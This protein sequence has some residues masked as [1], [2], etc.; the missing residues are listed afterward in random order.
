MD[1]LSAVLQEL[2]FNAEVFFSGS[3]CGLQAFEQSDNNGHLHLMRAG[4]MTMLTDQ[5]HEV[6]LQKASVLFLPSGG[7]HRIQIKDSHDAELVCA[8]VQFDSH[9][10]SVL[11][12]NL[13]KFICLDVETN[14]S[15][16]A[17]VDHIFQEAFS[18]QLGKK[19]V[20]DRL[21]DVFVVQVLRYVIEGGMVDAGAF[22]AATHPQL[23][24]LMKQLKS[25]P[26][27]VWT[28]ESM[29]TFAA[30]SRSKFAGLFKDSVGQSPMEYLTQLRLELAKELLLKNK[31]VS[32]VADQVGYD[33]ASSLARA[34]KKQLDLSPK[35]WIKAQQT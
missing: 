19:I 16:S 10:K 8:N 7:D 28:V 3:L 34:F 12:D 18:D 11:V 33:S 5:G 23:S 22:A 32:L 2:D 31:P 17:T 25:Q 30:M 14:P 9:Q 29:A 6:H 20:I 15:I 13:P 21:C 26:Q 27:S 1:S 35:Q 24:E 4:S